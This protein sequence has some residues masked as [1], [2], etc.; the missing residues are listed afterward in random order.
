MERS[1]KKLSGAQVFKADE[2]PNSTDKSQSSD[3]KSFPLPLNRPSSPSSEQWGFSQNIAGETRPV[4]GAS[5]AS[6]TNPKSGLRFFTEAMLGET[7]YWN[8]T[9]VTDKDG[10]ARVTFRLPERST[11]WRLRAAGIDGESLAGEADADLV[12]KKDFFGEMK[13]P[14]AFTA[15]DRADVL[16]DV[17]NAS[18]ESGASIEVRLKLTLNDRTTELRKSLVSRARESNRSC[19]RLLSAKR[20]RPNLS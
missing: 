14:G 13:L 3:S 10:K 2:N 5:A 1:K 11:A 9:I 15:G 18:V 19:S 7:G 6:D 20:A 16:V 4:S 12:A 8:P 17:Q